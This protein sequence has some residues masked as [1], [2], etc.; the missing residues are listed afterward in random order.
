[1]PAAFRFESRAEVYD[2]GNPTTRTGS[3][4]CEAD[5]RKWQVVAEFFRSTKSR[6][7]SDSC[8]PKAGVTGS[9][10]VG[11][12][13]FFKRLRGFATLPIGRCDH[14]VAML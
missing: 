13:I 12:A 10:P 6:P 8:T 1:M 4:G 2:T 3:I 9:N 14:H 7:S 5:A 11:R